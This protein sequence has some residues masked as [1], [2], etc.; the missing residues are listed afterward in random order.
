ME[1]QNKYK[2]CSNLI[3]KLLKQ[4][5]QSYFAKCFRE[6]I[7]DLKNTLIGK[8]VISMETSKQTSLDVIIDNNATLTNPI[9]IA[10]VFNKYLSTIA[11]DIY[12]CIRYYFDFFPPIN[13]DSFFILYSHCNEVFSVISFLNDHEAAGPSSIPTIILKL[14]NKIIS[15]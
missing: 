3:L 12:S 11:L 2:K 8:N 7:K 5:K 6:N 4:S 15:N 10:N 13:S 1:A 14:F 9:A